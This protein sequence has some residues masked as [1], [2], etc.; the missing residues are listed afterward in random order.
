MVICLHWL[1]PDQS[2]LFQI[3]IMARADMHNG[4]SGTIKKMQ[5]DN[6]DVI[7]EKRSLEYPRTESNFAAHI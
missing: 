6:N 7:A 4:A 3:R 1:S 2:Y 5:G